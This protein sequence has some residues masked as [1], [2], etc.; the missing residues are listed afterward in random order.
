[1]NLVCRARV[2][3]W[4][5]RGALTLLLV[6]AIVPAV[7][8]AVPGALTFV[9][10]TKDGV[11][12]A[13]GMD[14]ADAVVVSPDGKHANVAGINDDAVATFARNAATGALTFV[15]MDKDGVGGV[16]GLDA[17]GLVAISPDGQSV[18]V[19]GIAEDAIA[20]FAR[21]ATSGALTFVEMDKDGVGGVDGLDGPVSLA[22]SADGKNVYVAGTTDSAI[23][24]FARDAGTGALTFVE[25]DKD[26]VGG[27]DGLN[28]T[29]ALAVAPDGK[30]VYVVAGLDDDVVT[31]SRDATTGALT[32]V[33]TD[34]DGVGGADGLDGAS[35]V[36]VSP[37]NKNVY[38]TAFGPGENSVATF[39]RNSGTGALGFVEADKDGVGGVDGL[40]GANDVVVAPDGKHVYTTAQSDDAV[41]TF[42]R[43]AASGTLTFLEM[44]KDGVDGVDGIDFPVAVAASADGKNVYTA[45]NNEDAVAVFSREQEPAPPVVPEPE[46]PAPAICNGKPATITGTEA[47]ESIRGTSGDDIISGLGG[48]DQIQAGKGNDIVCAGLGKDRV[49]GRAGN[50]RL[51]GEAG[52][53]LLNGG[54]GKDVL[55]G[56][57][58]KDTCNGGAA[59]DKAKQCE[60]GPDS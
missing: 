27:V 57:I 34:Q 56:G 28:G 25:M 26:G 20:T 55:N 42:V 10:I 8:L 29:N 18:Y 52:K 19:L 60:K 40:S 3:R 45:S 58:S 47:N 2:A 38:I 13:D 32:F 12:G 6:A 9:G 16:D 49:F 17:A 51:L 59:K 15:E 43:D 54:P 7:A 36:D 23:A 1:M 39:E 11:G 4:V 14:A 30:H 21:N 24:T 5:R 31:F 37:D 44:E 35:D 53:D 46:P 48:R 50:D 33:K 41:A 22:T